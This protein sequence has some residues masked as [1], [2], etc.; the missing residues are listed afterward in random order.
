MD[1]LVGSPTDT[2]YVQPLED[3]EIL[4]LN[5]SNSDCAMVL[6]THRNS[7]RGK[8][9]SSNKQGFD[10]NA[11]VSKKT[12]LKTKVI[13]QNLVK[14]VVNSGIGGSGQSN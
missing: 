8:S 11:K 10:S 6:H 2:I 12:K 7:G 13:N 1:R 4:H 14:D 9:K 5:A 3:D